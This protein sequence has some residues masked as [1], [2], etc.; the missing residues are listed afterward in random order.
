MLGENFSIIHQLLS[1][2]ELWDAAGL[3]DEAPPE[4]LGGWLDKTQPDF[5]LNWFA[6][7]TYDRALAVRRDRGL[8]FTLPLINGGAGQ[9]DN[10]P[11]YPIPFSPRLIEGRA[12]SGAAHPQLLFKLVL[13]DGS[14]LLPTSFMQD[15]RTWREGEMHVLSYRQPGLNLTGERAPR[16]DTR[17]TLVT[18]Y[19]FG[20]GFISRSDTLHPG[21]PLQVAALSLEFACPSFGA[22]ARGSAVDFDN[23][24]LSRFAA[25][26]F[27]RLSVHEPA[28][29]ALR[30]LTSGPA[31]THLHFSRTAT[32]MAAPISLRWTLSYR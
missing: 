21:A 11:Y 16:L 13:A 28:P 6:R 10:A 26:G 3:A 12:E 27:E 17:A 1:T 32:Q 4:E 19:R 20:P 25:E 5:A 22:Q 9:H 29:T 24:V 15:L 23:G 2:C 18:E 8:V 7:G 14:V 31:R 30:S